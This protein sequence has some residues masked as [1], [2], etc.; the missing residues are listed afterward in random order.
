MLTETKTKKIFFLAIS[1]LL[2][3]GTTK[4]QIDTVDIKPFQQYWTRA[5]VVP[6]VGFGVQD[7]GFG[8]IGLQLHQIYVH[9]LSLA[10]A[11]PYIT[12]DAVFQADDII[13]GPKA[14][15]ELTVGLLGI[16]ADFT[17]Y[18]DFDRESVMFT[19]KAGITLLGY[20]NLF[21]GRN[22]ALSDDSFRSISQNRFSLIFNINPDYYNIREAQRK[23]RKLK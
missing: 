4:A 6:K 19:P 7:T 22:I 20:V 10:S 14:G 17:Y 15:Y 16:A 21:Y 3:M 12:V 23:Q 9:P 11:G 5:R 8:E 2:V 13:V 18:T 1:F